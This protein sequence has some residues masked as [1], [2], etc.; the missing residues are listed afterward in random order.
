MGSL[1]NFISSGT[2]LGL[3]DDIID[4]TIGMLVGPILWGLCDIFFLI[5]DMFESLYKRFAGIADITINGEVVDQDPVLYLIN[6]NIVQEMFFSILTLSLVLLIIFTIFAIV[7]NIY[8]EKPKPIGQIL[9]S[10][11]KALLMYLLV[12]V[13][14]VVCLL[15]GN[16]VLRAID[17]ATKLGGA[18]S[19]SDLLFISAAYN[20]SKV[21][22]GDE[23]E[24]PD[25][26]KD[27]HLTPIATT[28]ANG[29]SSKYEAY[30]KI[31][32]DNGIDVIN[33]TITDAS[34]M[35]V[36]EIASA[37]DA[38]IFGYEMFLSGQQF[39]DGDGLVSDGVEKTLVNIGR[40]GSVGM[41]ETDKEIIRIMTE[42]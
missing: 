21:R 26:V 41:K 35:D 28:D 29:D 24:I 38:G 18:S 3:I 11:V 25:M 17:G 36:E 16:I 1:L 39:Y 15:V 40:L 27:G 10:S 7:K 8:T 30:V 13:A 42:C 31:M 4:N 14:T 19:T 5:L 34:K 6:T 20:A 23:T 22:N 12:P 9:S 33:K 2:M 37:V 32:D